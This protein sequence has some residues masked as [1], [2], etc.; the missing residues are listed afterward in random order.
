MTMKWTRVF[1]PVM[2]LAFGA[3]FLAAQPVGAAAPAPAA[4]PSVAEVTGALPAG[5]TPDTVIDAQEFSEVVD[6]TQRLTP[7]LYVGDDGLVRLRDVSA[8]ELG[9]SEQFLAN[10]REA[11]TYSNQLIARGEMKVEKDMRTTMTARETLRGQIGVEPGPGADAAGAAA[12]ADGGAA[13]NWGGWDYGTGAMFYSSY[14]DWTYYRY[15]YYPLCNTMAAYIYRPWMSTSL[16]NFWGYNQSY[17]QNYCVNPLG[18]YYYMPY[19]YCCQQTYSCGSGYKPAYFWTRA[20]Y[21]QSSCRCYQY[22]WN[23]QQFY[24]RY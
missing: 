22:N 20:Y 21:Y 7:H 1:I 9:V 6:I 13:P 18:T 5:M 4:M 12:A 14:G 24:L 19:Q 8:A 15:N 11:M 23:W 17:F 10:F 2:A 16:C 3:G